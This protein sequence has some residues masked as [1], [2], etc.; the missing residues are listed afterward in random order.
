MDQTDSFG[1][2]GCHAKRFQDYGK[3]W[4]GFGQ[5]N[6]IFITV[7]MGFGQEKSLYGIHKPRVIDFFYYLLLLLLLYLIINN[8][9]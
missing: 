2:N 7:D 8:N 1:H 6:R 5:R 3:M 9:N 4:F